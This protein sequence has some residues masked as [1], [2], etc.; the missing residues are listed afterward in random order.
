M[1]ETIKEVLELEDKWNNK[2]YFETCELANPIKSIKSE[3]KDVMKES[4][5]C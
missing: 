2:E 4:K 3:K 5:T 1:K